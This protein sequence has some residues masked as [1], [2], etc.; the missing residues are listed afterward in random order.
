MRNKETIKHKKE[1]RRY[2][3]GIRSKAK[4]I[5]INKHKK[6]YK[7]IIQ[8]LLKRRYFENITKK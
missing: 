4:T 2:Y 5:L 3:E 8:K 6:E 7:K 1:V